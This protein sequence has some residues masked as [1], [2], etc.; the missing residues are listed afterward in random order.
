MT[1]E[2][3]DTEFE[4]WPVVIDLA[5]SLNTAATDLLLCVLELTA[6]GSPERKLALIELMSSLERIRAALAPKPRLN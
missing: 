5:D 2:H 6:E 3:N 1:A 4:P